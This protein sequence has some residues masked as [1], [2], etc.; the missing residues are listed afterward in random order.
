MFRDMNIWPFGFQFNLAH[1]LEEP[2]FFIWKYFS[3]YSQFSIELSNFKAK[4]A[5]FWG[6]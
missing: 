4:Y 6:I 3:K 5:T 2:E 1:G